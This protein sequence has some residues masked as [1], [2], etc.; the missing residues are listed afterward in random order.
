[1]SYC[2]HCGGDS[3]IYICIFVYEAR[4]C[5]YVCEMSVCVYLYACQETI[6]KRGFTIEG[7][8]MRGSIITALRVLQFFYFPS[9]F[10][11]F[12]FFFFFFLFLLHDTF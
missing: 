11:T 1:V 7:S 9:I 8:H 5:V 3:I 10:E 6:V 2:G 12:F 4:V